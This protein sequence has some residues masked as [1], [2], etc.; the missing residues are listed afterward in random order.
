[1]HEEARQRLAYEAQKRKDRG[2]S[3]RSISRALGIH[4]Q[5]VQR[6]LQELAARREAGESSLERE[7]GPAPIPRSSKLDPFLEQIAYWLKTYENLTAV[8]LLEKLKDEGFT[9]S[10]TIVREHL[11]QL[12]G[13]GTQQE[14]FQVIETPAGH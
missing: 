9:G 4:R 10:Y 1:M 2:D 3:V 14:A 8:R 11:K 7:V 13:Q 5:T 12:R 6:L